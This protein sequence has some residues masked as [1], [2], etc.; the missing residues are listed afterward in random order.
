[1]LTVLFGCQRDRSAAQLQITIPEA[2]Q[3]AEVYVDGNY[4]GLVRALHHELTGSILLAPGQHRLEI[5]K[6]G[7]FP[8][9]KTISIKRPAPAQVVIQAELLTDPL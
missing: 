5:R 1:M 4:V 2:D 9:Q 8:F 7:R 3:D 6:P